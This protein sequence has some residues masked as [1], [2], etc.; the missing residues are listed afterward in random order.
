[1]VKAAAKSGCFCAAESWV[2]LQKHLPI[3][4]K[5]GYGV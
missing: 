5:R 2:E 1:M 3:E 4:E